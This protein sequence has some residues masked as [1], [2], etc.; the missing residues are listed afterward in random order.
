M[1]ESFYEFDVRLITPK[2]VTDFNTY[3]GSLPC[4]IDAS[5]GTYRVDGRSLM[6][7]YS[8][9]LSENITITLKSKGDENLEECA[10][11]FNKWRVT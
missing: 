11:K 2:D 1:S 10:A 3:A 5:R 9:N 7:L 6:G 8:L 4:D